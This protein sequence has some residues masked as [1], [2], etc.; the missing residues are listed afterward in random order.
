VDG[1]NL[2]IIPFSASRLTVRRFQFPGDVDVVGRVTGVAMSLTAHRRKV[3]S[4]ISDRT[5]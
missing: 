5:A 3:V 2:S 4:D 1:G